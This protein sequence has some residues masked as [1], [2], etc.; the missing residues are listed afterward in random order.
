MIVKGLYGVIA[1]IIIIVAIIVMV[2]QCRI[3]GIG[4]RAVATAIDIAVDGGEDADSI[5][6]IDIS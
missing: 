1:W 5:T 2:F 4:V 6:A 3:V